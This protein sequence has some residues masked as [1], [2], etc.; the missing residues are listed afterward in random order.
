MKITLNEQLSNVPNYED[1]L[2]FIVPILTQIKD[3][4][5]GGITA[6]DNLT[7]SVVSYNFTAANTTFAINHNIGF[8]P[9]GYIKVSGPDIRV[10]DG[11][12]TST[13]QQI[14]LQ[15]SGTGTVKLLVFV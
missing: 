12:G 15:A 13:K 14:F 11:V 7:A 6:D 10:F 1:F 2:R 4:L 8:V 5:N 3:A 9:T